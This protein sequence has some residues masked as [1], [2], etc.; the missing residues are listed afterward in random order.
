M[1]LSPVHDLPAGAYMMRVHQGN[2]PGQVLVV[3]A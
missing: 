2:T 3:R 1:T